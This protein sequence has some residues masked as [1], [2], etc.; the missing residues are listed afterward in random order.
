MIYGGK[1]GFSDLNDVVFEAHSKLSA[2]L[3]KF[4]SIAVSGTS[5][6]VVGAPLAVLLNKPLVVVRKDND[7]SHN[8][9]SVMV[10]G[11]ADMG[12]RVL[13]LDDFV[14]TGKTR[15]WVRHNVRDWSG[16]LIG[17]YVYYSSG[18]GELKWYA[19]EPWKADD[20]GYKVELP[21]FK[22]EY[23]GSTIPF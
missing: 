6:L 20:A 16:D 2:V 13:F 10:E 15:A 9:E 7:G 19:G 11:N 14:G 12:K 21:K 4:D 5:G 22:T 1:R 8:G 23:P 18:R 3:D 17:E